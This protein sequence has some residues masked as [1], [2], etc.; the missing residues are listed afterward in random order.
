M[1]WVSTNNDI[2]CPT[3]WSRP[4][5]ITYARF[6]CWATRV[7]YHSPCHHIKVRNFSSCSVFRCLFGVSDLGVYGQN[8]ELIKNP[9]LLTYYGTPVSSIRCGPGPR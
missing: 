7:H 5:A 4:A 6:A 8:T 3:S 9:Q 1:T 2:Q